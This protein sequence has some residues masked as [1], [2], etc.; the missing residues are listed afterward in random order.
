MTDE[1]IEGIKGGPVCFD[2]KDKRYVA[3][4]EVRDHSGSDRDS[5][6]H[7]VEHLVYLS[8]VRIP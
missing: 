8:N 7:C 3:K 1:V 4:F 6:V 5:P 2:K